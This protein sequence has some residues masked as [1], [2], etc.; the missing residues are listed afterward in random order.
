MSP[1]C[2]HQ[3]AYRSSPRLYISS[4]MALRPVFGPMASPTFFLYSPLSLAA[5][6]QL[7]IWSRLSASLCMTS[8]Q[9]F[10]GLPTGLSP[11]QLPS[12]LNDIYEHGE[13]WWNDIDR[14][15]LLIRPSEVSW[16]TTRCHL[17]ASRRNRRREWWILHT[18]R[19]FFICHKIL[20]H[21]ASGLTYSP[22][23][24]ILQF[25]SP[26]KIHCLSQIWT[27]EPSV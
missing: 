2:D 18:C 3:W 17:V 9:L 27:R 26:L 10:R 22:K 5:A 6:F 11:K 15:K 19:W 4:F 24:G 14:S 1:K 7:Q 16:N 8:S 12:T 21:G 20:W 25:L 23:E 13:P